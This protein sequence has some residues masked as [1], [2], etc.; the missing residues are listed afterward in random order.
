[1]TTELS[2]LLAEL[3]VVH[4]EL[5]VAAEDDIERLLELQRRQD[6]LRARARDAATPGRRSTRAGE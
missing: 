6:E 2:E 4:D 3:S 1:M 5:S